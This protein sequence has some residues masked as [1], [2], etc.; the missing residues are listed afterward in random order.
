MMRARIEIKGTD[1]WCRFGSDEIRLPLAL[2]LDRMIEWARQYDRALA[3][4]EGGMLSVIG[5]EM[6]AWMNDSGWATRWLGQTGAR[7]LEMAG[8]SPLT[9]EEEILFDL[10]WEVLAFGGDF[11]AA[12]SV[13]L[14]S[15]FRSIGR[16][17]AEVPPVPAH[18]D[19]AALFMAAAPPGQT[20]LNFEGEEAAILAA[21]NGL[22]MHLMVEE[23]GCLTFLGWRVRDDGPFDVVHLS[24]HGDISKDHIPL[25]MLETAE[26]DA[27]LVPADELIDTLGDDRVPMMFL[28]ACRT[29]ETDGAEPFVRALVRAGMPNVLGWDGSVRDSDAIKFASTLYRKLAGGVSVPSAAATARNVLLRGHLDDPASGQ[30]WHLARVY[31]GPQGAGKLCESGR[32]KRKLTKKGDK[33]FL[34]KSENGGVKVA[35]AREFVGRRRNAQTILR[36]FREGN[37]AG[38][39]IHGMGNLGK[40]SLAQ[41]VFTRMDG[42]YDAVVV[43][44][45]YDALTVFD[46]LVAALPERQREDWNGYWRERIIND[47]NLLGNAV[48]E[49]LKGAF[50]DRP[51]LLVIDDLEQILEQPVPGQNEVRVLPAYG[52]MLAALIRAFDAAQSESRLLLTSRYRFTLPDGKGRDWADRLFDVPLLP[53]DEGERDKQWR[54]AQ[55]VKPRAGDC[56]DG[57]PALIGRAVTAAAG[58][59]GL[60]E[61][62]CRPILAGEAGPARAAVDAVEKF[63]ASG[64]VPGDENRAQEFFRRVSFDVYRQALTNTQTQALHAATLFTEG[65]PIPLTALAAAAR[66]A[67][68]TDPQA[69]LD[70]LLGLGLMDDW[71]NAHAAAN[72]LA[73]PLGGAEWT[74]DE[75]AM[76][77]AAAMAPLATAWRDGEGD[78]PFDPRGVEAARLALLADAASDVLDTTARAGAVFLFLKRHDAAAALD[79]FERALTLIERRGGSPSPH[80]LQ[81]AAKCAERIGEVNRQI[82]LLEKGL[83]LI[84][85]N[86]VAL[87]QITAEYAS[88]T[89][90]RHGPEQSLT[91]L[92]EAA[93]VFAAAGDVHSRAVTMGK[94][95]GIL[96]DRGELDQALRISR[97]EQLPVYDRLGDIRERAVTM[98]RIADILQARGELDQALRIRREEQLPVYDRLGDIRARAITLGKIA[99][100][101]Q[102]RGELDEALR[103]R[104]EEELPVYDRLGDI[105]SRAVTMGQIA[106]ILHSR[107]E[108]DEALRIRREEQL[109][110]YDRLGDIRAR[111]VTMGKIADILQGRG[112][113][114][115]ALRIHVEERLPTALTMGDQEAIAHIRY[116]CA[117]I[118]LDRGGLNGEEVQTIVEELAESFAIYRQQQHADGI[119]TV[120]ALFGQVLA[121]SGMD[122]EALAVLDLSAAAFDKLQWTE[123]A[124]QVRGIQ[125]QIRQKQGNPKNDG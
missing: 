107:G 51:V 58:N 5:S 123:N 119:A 12:D 75:Q 37:F 33:E 31:A 120:G 112:E 125:A 49:A 24:C 29:A 19:L 40:S 46:R 11:L 8:S 27:C 102:A 106:T 15:V 113:L 26:G 109:P 89:I 3:S 13:Q 63:K 14:Y 105:R 57:E 72:P 45:R 71:G 116:S 44:G 117:S 96:Q 47:N 87:A 70:R 53:M 61:I 104:H 55:A 56:G 28:S 35:S 18:S 90:S 101:L 4:G 30:H 84:T 23:S 108:L 118:R 52:D 77:A 115:E 68:V 42:K 54:A 80:F 81:I 21:T 98:G 124:A 60:Q 88:A 7:D 111:A 95:A 114:D 122:D 17:S 1:V 32:P 69:A 94:I 103:I 110:V 86:K 79:L 65:L 85:G 121:A 78:F 82:G 66:A 38:V 20:V 62:L 83:A 64:E 59:P 67:G 48:E 2:S 100:I 76:L 39:L 6:L 9:N 91:T 73:R 97:E 41:R 25:L 74:E 34:G 99:D 43:Y 92:R 22:P 10:P 36:T 93:D 50:N 16:P